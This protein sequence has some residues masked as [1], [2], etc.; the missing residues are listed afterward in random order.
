MPGAAGR[1]AVWLPLLVQG[2]YTVEMPSRMRVFGGDFTFERDRPGQPWRMA[3]NFGAEIERA[4][5]PGA[6]LT[7][8]PVT[9]SGTQ[10]GVV[11]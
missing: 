7:D 3:A 1:H 8:S 2:K 4:S 6:G 10:A 11:K 5:K 9:L